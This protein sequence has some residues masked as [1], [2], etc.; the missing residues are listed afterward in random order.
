MERGFTSECTIKRTVP[1]A[2]RTIRKRY[3]KLRNHG[4]TGGRGGSLSRWSGSDQVP[5]TRP[6]SFGG[7]VTGVQPERSGR[8]EAG[9]HPKTRRHGDTCRHTHT[10]RTKQGGGKRPHQQHQG[11]RGGGAGG[12]YVRLHSLVRRGVRCVGLGVR[13]LRA[14]C[15]KR[16]R[17]HPPPT[18]T[19]P[20]RTT[21]CTDVHVHVHA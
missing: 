2:T 11:Q 6:P 18:S 20:N 4:G 1:T 8:S 21:G 5:D 19:C 7:A 3:K 12:P 15:S 16:P 10:Q 17:T 14:A 9:V 13:A